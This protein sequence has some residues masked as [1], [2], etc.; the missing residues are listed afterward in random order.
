MREADDAPNR[1]V[2]ELLERMASGHRLVMGGRE[3]RWMAARGDAVLGV[4]DYGTVRT[5]IF[6][7]WV[8]VPTTSA[9]LQ[10]TGDAREWL[11]RRAA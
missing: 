7:G 9:D 1:A 3:Y 11:R 10:L 8:R 5:A 4:A 6:G 2:R